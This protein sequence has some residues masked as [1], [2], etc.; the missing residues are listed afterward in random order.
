MITGQEAL[1]DNNGT[2]E[3]RITISIVNWNGMEY[4]PACLGSLREQTFKDFRIIIVDNGSS[5]GSIQWLKENAPEVELIEAGENLGF[6]KAHNIALNATKG[7]YVLVLNFDIILEPDFLEVLRKNMDERPQVGMA[8][9]KL[10]K[11]FNGNKSNILDSTGILM[12]R[13]MQAARGEME[14]D[15]GQYDNE[16]S[17]DIFG[18]CGAA[19]L[20]RRAML[21]DIAFEGREYFDEDYIL[22]V[23][24]VDLAWRGQLMG[25]KAAYFAQAVAYHERGATRKNSKQASY[26]YLVIGFSNRLCGIYKNMSS[27]MFFRFFPKIFF[28]E[29][30]SLLFKHN[31]PYSVNYKTLTRFWT[32]LP[33]MRR[34]REFI[35][36]SIQVD[37]FYMEKYFKYKPY[38][39]V[40]HAAAGALNLAARVFM[41]LRDM[42]KGDLYD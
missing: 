28:H 26:D 13:C 6:S 15:K 36:D 1:A 10:R 2:A 18:P 24:D 12:R 21:D 29:A 37:P 20:Y 8:S 32:L 31:Y 14:E 25:W 16:E 17:C 40:R 19:P 7:E 42:I 23:E 41:K 11:L 3:P 38:S 33:A 5:D 30:G 4:L 9:G 35:Q 34:K 27:R 39:I 22:Y